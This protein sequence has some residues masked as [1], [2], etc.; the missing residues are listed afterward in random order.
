MDRIEPVN[1][2]SEANNNPTPFPA[3]PDDVAAVSRTP[4]Q[5]QSQAALMQPGG[6][7][8]PSSISS[9]RRP[10]IRIS[11]VPSIP[12]LNPIRFDPTDHPAQLP[13]LQ[14]LSPLTEGDEAV[15]NRRR[16]S[17]DPRFGRWVAPQRPP[18]SSA[19][20]SG[21]NNASGSPA[22]LPLIAEASHPNAP[23]AAPIDQGR[24][25]EELHVPPPVLKPESKGRLRRV[26]SAAIPRF[27]G[28]DRSA[29]VSAGG[30]GAD[31]RQV[32]EYDPRIVDVLDVIG[33]LYG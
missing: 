27:R 14:P 16:S 21:T 7:S 23:Q 31:A 32:A 29:T 11:R 18:I 2:N 4:S 30:S 28:R 25:Q 26:S 8:R 22:V 5:S 33:R 12:T 9:Q 15:Q 17:S 20:G 24:P 10:S 19:Q 3:L 1:S 6:R 13:P